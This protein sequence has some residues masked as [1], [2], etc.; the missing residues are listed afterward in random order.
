MRNF[1]ARWARRFLHTNNDECWARHCFYVIERAILCV[2]ALLSC[3]MPSCI[4]LRRIVSCGFVLLEPVLHGIVLLDLLYAVLLCAVS[5]CSG[6]PCAMLP[7]A[8]LPCAVSFCVSLIRAKNLYLS[9]KRFCA[10][11]PQKRSFE[12]IIHKRFIIS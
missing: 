5:F 2:S 7:C 12:A 10:F 9:I 6:L 4:V 1:V 11:A 3:C 8:R